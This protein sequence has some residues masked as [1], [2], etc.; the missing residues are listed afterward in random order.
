MRPVPKTLSFSKECTIQILAALNRNRVWRQP[1][2]SWLSPMLS[3]FSLGILRTDCSRIVLCPTSI[4][5]RASVWDITCANTSAQWPPSR[6]P[7][8]TGGP[9]LPLVV[10]R[11][12]IDGRIYGYVKRTQLP[13][14]RPR[15]V[16][17]FFYRNGRNYFTF[18]SFD[19][20]LFN[21]VWRT[22]PHYRHT[23]GFRVRGV[24]IPDARRVPLL[25]QP[26]A[27]ARYDLLLRDLTEGAPPHMCHLAGGSRSG[28]V[29]AV[30]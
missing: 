2:K 15:F 21:W 16:W 3:L 1:S 23:H 5:Q 6:C 30:G 13:G 11:C 26:S 29:S 9:R 8:T 4:R 24:T 27:Y 20:D 17:P 25:C 19:D 7:T 12:K 10:H 18:L 14:M 22:L 28:A